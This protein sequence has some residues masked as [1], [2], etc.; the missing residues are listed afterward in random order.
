[1][2]SDAKPLGKH[3]K[4]FVMGFVSKGM[5]SHCMDVHGQS[6]SKINK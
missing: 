3:H 2:M 4:A 1:M 5:A 6:D